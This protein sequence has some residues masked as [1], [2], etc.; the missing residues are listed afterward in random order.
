MTS[1]ERIIKTVLN[2]K[3][4]RVPFI[5]PFGPWIETVELWRTQGLG[6]NEDYTARTGCDAGFLPVPA[7]W[8]NLGYCPAFEERTISDDG[9]KRIFLN[10]QGIVTEVKHGNVSIPNFLEYPVKTPDD[11][12]R[13]KEERLQ[14]KLEER[15]TVDIDE[16]K[17]WA[18]A[19]DGPIQLGN[20]PYG[21]FGTA[22][23]LI[24]VEELLMW[25]YDYPEVIADIMDTLT[26]L[27]LG[28]YKEI[29][30]HIQID[31]IHI[32]E[33]MSGKQGPLISPA[34]M[35]EFMVPNYKRIRKFCD[36]NNIPILSLDTDGD[37][38]LLF[39]PLIEGGINLIYPFEVAAGSDVVE[40]KKRY[41]TQFCA[42]GGI[43][44]MEIAKGKYAIDKEIE[45]IMP[46]IESG[47]YIPA[48]DHLIHPEVS[49]EDFLYF[50]KKLRGACGIE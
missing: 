1:R 17:A 45:R 44:K 30:K 31:C 14:P 38:D 46:A 12:K 37:C 22:R 9:N 47:G 25:F 35:Y 26:D 40:I 42:M 28:I 39:D 23:D 5:F 10:Y 34:M 21:L 15:I 20:F 4:D 29:A 32:W 27:W 19:H 33:D 8:I 7:S 3:T 11:W 16:L 2:E 6:A 49:Y 50:A 13:L 18:V 43:D 48:F 36:E 24:G 41:P